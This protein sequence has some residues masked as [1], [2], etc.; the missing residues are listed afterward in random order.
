ML[1]TSYKI[2][3]LTVLNKNIHKDRYAAKV[4]NSWQ[5]AGIHCFSQQPFLGCLK[6][7]HTE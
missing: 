3:T 5:L 1:H 2:F 7:P 6:K 4:Q